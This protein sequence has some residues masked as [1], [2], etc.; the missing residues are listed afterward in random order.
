MGSMMSALLILALASFVS[1]PLAKRFGRRAFYALAAVMTIVFCVLLAPSIGAFNG[2]VSVEQLSWVPQLHLDLTFRLD[3]LSA[4]FALL[5]TGA[6]ALVLLYCANYFDDGEMGIPRFAGVFMAFA[7]SMLGL[8]IADNVFLLFVFWE[9]TT[10][11]SFLLIGHVLSLRT[12]NAAALQALM[13]TTL[14][15]LAMLVGFVL[16]VQQTG[17]PLLSEILASA[18]SGTLVTVSVYLILLGAISKS[19]IFPLHF[20][21][22]GAMTAPTPVSAYLH[23]AAM[24]KAGVFILARMSGPFSDI[25]GYRL[26]L[27]LLGGI[28]MIAGGL[29]ALRQFDIKLIVAHGTVSQL[30]LLVMVIG[31]GDPRATF[32]G[33]ALLFA[34]AAAKAPLFLTVG[35]IDS[36]TGIRDMRKLSGIGRRF[37][38]LA[39]IALAATASMAGAP[40]FFG[41]VA[42]EAA[43]TELLAVGA[44]QPLALVALWTAVGGSVLTMA[45]MIRFAWGAFSRKRGVSDTAIQQ[46][47]RF[48]FFLAPA[49]FAIITLV[50]GFLAPQFDLLIRSSVPESDL[51]ATAAQHLALWHGFNLPLLLSALVIVVG[52]ALFLPLRRL[53]EQLPPT[54]ERLSASHA[55]WV[56]THWLDL[57]AVRITLLTQRGS[58]PFYLAVILGTLV[59]TLGGVTLAVKPWPDSISF[60]TSPV[61]I[62]VAIVIIVAAV[63]AIRAR[64]RFQAAVL[65]GVTGYGMA[66]IFAL[67]GSPDLALT[68]LLVETVTLFAFVLVIRQLPA[69][70]S[71]QSSR[72]QRIV[73]I[74]LGIGVGLVLGAV[75]V[76]ALGARVADPVS[77]AFPE[78]AVFGGHGSNIV[79]VTLVDIRGWDTM[80]ELSVVLA[81]ATGVASLVFLNTRI[82]QSPHLSR[83]AARNATRAHMLRVADPDDP[84]SRMNWL[85]AGSKLDPHRRSIILE[86]IVR[87]IFHGLLILSIFLLLSGHNSPGGGFAGGLVAGLAL[88]A[89]YLAG[90]RYELRATVP[91]DAGRILGIGLALA[92]TTATVPLFFGQPALASSWIDVDLGIFGSLPLVTSTLFDIGVY[93]V[94]FGLVL[95]VL[96]S[97]GSEIDEHEE[98]ISESAA[99]EWAK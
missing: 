8:V 90:G 25:P 67:H 66:I 98:N 99:E 65:V 2:D 51:G 60:V 91:L 88:V 85:L 70:M 86:V 30:G 15:G 45:Y 54:I 83:R 33:L 4:L 18:P 52:A 72:F 55:Y 10:V 48:A 38:V 20:W 22:P 75:A 57:F 28:T 87:I 49:L 1:H 41:F 35:I 93:L 44:E 3:S 21:L 95:D 9:A 92:V 39:V 96:R 63:F 80:G 47:P 43:F 76:V 5:V 59:L 71:S 12:A 19:A 73:R 46:Q 84:V 50:L 24:V 13:I 34:H 77:L 26:T 7:T 36:S 69:R 58:L 37:P 31:V 23:A 64:T 53:A 62:P 68:Q 74:S 78:L 6:G 79:N 27:V 94:V 56:F 81:A 16:L 11:F 97:L 14:G 17:T 61:D 32:A 82:D 40:P 29:R 89:R 42:K